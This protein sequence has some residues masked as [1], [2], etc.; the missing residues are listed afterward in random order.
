MGLLRVVFILE[1][2]TIY[3]NCPIGYQV[4][5]IIPLRGKLVCGL[6]VEYNLQYLTAN[7]NLKKGNKYYDNEIGP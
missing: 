7:E 6:H 3:K 2:K 4:D 5:H 1:M